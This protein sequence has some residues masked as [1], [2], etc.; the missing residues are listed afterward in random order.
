M[1]LDINLNM[2]VSLSGTRWCPSCGKFTF[3]EKQLFT[4]V[5]TTAYLLLR[6]WKRDSNNKKYK[7]FLASFGR[8][9]PSS[10]CTQGKIKGE[11]GRG[12]GICLPWVILSGKIGAQISSLPTCSSLLG[13]GTLDTVTI[14]VLMESKGNQPPPPEKKP[15]NGKL[16]VGEPDLKHLECCQKRQCSL[17]GNHW[18][19]SYWYMSLGWKLSFLHSEFIIFVST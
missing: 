14:A 1:K 13:T 3:P 6:D 7:W 19:T 9:L 17:E 8:A 15:Q 10:T 18:L 12:P 2:G 4:G 16:E 11:M 5:P